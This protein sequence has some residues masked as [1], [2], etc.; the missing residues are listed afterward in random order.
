[1]MAAF[2]HN[3]SNIFQW[4]QSDKTTLTKACKGMQSL[5]F[6]EVL[7]HRVL[8]RPL[9]SRGVAWEIQFQTPS[10]I[11]FLHLPANSCRFKRVSSNTLNKALLIGLEVWWAKV[12]SQWIWSTLIMFIFYWGLQSFCSDKIVVESL[13][14]LRDLI[15]DPQFHMV[16][17]NSCRLKRVSPKHIKQHYW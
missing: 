17:A 15:P 10:S 9:L 8:I 3:V 16:P 2:C 12:L 6:T 13:C 1:M 14:C 4:T 11:Y 7:S 5:S